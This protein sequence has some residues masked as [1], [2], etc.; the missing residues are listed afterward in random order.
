[1]ICHGFNSR[2]AV[3][4]MFGIHHG[5]LKG[6]CLLFAHYETD[7]SSSGE[8]FVFFTEVKT[9]KLFIVRGV[10]TGVNWRS[11]G[12]EMRG[13]FKGQWDPK[14]IK[15]EIAA[16]MKSCKSNF[17]VSKTLRRLARWN[18]MFGKYHNHCV[19]KKETKTSW[20]NTFASLLKKIK[21][22]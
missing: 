11:V 3:L 6:T 8:A 5:H 13:L 4:R 2:E 10:H 20:T 22:F 19:M 17:Y 1:M 14:E 7:G 18:E 12:R 9:R 15:P 21:I 16:K